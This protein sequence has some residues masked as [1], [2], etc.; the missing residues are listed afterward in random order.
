LPSL[1]SLAQYIKENSHLPNMPS[2]TEVQQNGIELGNMNTRIVEKLEELTLY[3]IELN[4]RLEKL[5]KENAALRN[6][7]QK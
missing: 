4:S 3:I 2:A 6:Q 7:L 5:E 1:A